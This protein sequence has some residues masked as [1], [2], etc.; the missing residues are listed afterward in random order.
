MAYP[1]F[2]PSK[3]KV[4]FFCRGNGRGHAIPDIEIVAKLMRDRPDVDVRFV[5]YG[6]GART[7][8]EFGQP[9]IRLDL[10]ERNGVAET[11]VLAGQAIGWLKPDLVVAHEEFAAMP[12]AK[13]FGKPTLMI[14]DWFSDPW[15]Y[16]MESL[17]FADSIVFIDDEG[18]FEE[19]EWVRGRVHYAGPVLR[20]FEYRH[21]DRVIARDE[22]SVPGNAFVVAMLPGSWTEAV[23]PVADLLIAAYDRLPEPKRMIWL[24]GEDRDRIAGNTVW[25]DGIDVRDRD[26]K[27]DR[28]IAACDV[29]ITKCNRKTLIELDHLGAPSISF[30]HGHNPVDERRARS[31]AGTR[32][33]A[34]DELDAAGL[35]AAIREA[36]ARGWSKPR[37]DRGGA[38]RAAKL[39]ARILDAH[40]PAAETATAAGA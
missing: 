4:L 19:P 40:L 6:T 16:Q 32:V 21:K 17:R 8:E 35:A 7:L 10:P 27:I 9:L 31:L 26:W 11:T 3:R 37:R 33:I 22:L 5:S 24:A 20:K 29:A 38:A 34:L 15:K 23:V 13:I 18:V 2:D 1:E 14:T 28:I 36:A 30:A 39:I 25:S 12:A